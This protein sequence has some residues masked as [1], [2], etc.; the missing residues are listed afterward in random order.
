[1]YISIF[2]WENK[3]MSS[4]KINILKAKIPCYNFEERSYSPLSYPCKILKYEKE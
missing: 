2:V 4:K 1:M 3:I